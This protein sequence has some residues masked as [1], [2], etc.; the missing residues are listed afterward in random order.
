MLGTIFQATV[1]LALK[2][3]R[4]AKVALESSDLLVFPDSGEAEDPITDWDQLRLSLPLDL[5][6][7]ISQAKR[8]REREQAVEQRRKARLLVKRQPRQPRQLRQPQTQLELLA[9]VTPPDRP[10]IQTEQ[11]EFNTWYLLA[12][13]CKLVSDY[14]RKDG[15]Y[16]VLA[17][18]WQPYTELSAAFTVKAM[19]RLFPRMNRELDDGN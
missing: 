11:Q 5:Q 10:P 15:E 6:Q 16:W 14:Q 12:Q 1:A 3:Q 8:R 17:N 19:Q 9:T 2:G 4:A 7:K 18:D 13:Q